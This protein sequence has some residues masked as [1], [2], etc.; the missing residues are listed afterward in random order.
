MNALK[1]TS[2]RLATLSVVLAALPT[3]MTQA[4]LTPARTYFG[5]NRP[6]P[7]NVAAS[8]SAELISIHLLEPGP[9]GSADAKIVEQLEVEAGGV[10]LA[11]LFPILWT[12]DKPRV[13]YAQLVVDHKGVGPAVILQ[14]MLSPR[15][16]HA[17]GDRAQTVRFDPDSPE[18]VYSG[19]RAYTDR[20]VV[21][22]TTEGEVVVA[23]RPDQAPNTSYNLITL[24]E[25]GY[26]TDI[27][28]H[29][30]V[31]KL[32]DGSQ[33]VVQFGDPTG[34]GSGG[35]GYFIDLEPSTL[36]HDFGVISMARSRDPD[37]NGSQVFLCLSRK[38]TAFLDN[39]YCA[40]G[41]AVQGADTIIRIEQTPLE[42]STSQKPMKPP[43][44]RSAHTVPAPPY[45][46]GP[47]PVS[48]PP[49]SDG[50]R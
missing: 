22:D 40:F 4:Q 49:S 21:F 3:A 26:Y 17:S 33:F 15:R 1:L 8:D 38:G 32:P 39:N 16:A 20:H 31:P 42:S 44:I 41:Q 43:V 6:I 50:S 35:P 11:G 13:L 34:T 30:V 10:D 25:G 24:A 46:T 48:R 14:P 12:S 27:I 5:I 36:P 45:G 9:N 47:M 28:V 7:M 29:R 23:L 37:T 2:F 18:R 19:I